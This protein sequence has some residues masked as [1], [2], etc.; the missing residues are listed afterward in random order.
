MINHQLVN[1]NGT[2]YFLKRN[3][4]ELLVKPDK[5]Q[6]LRELLKCDIVLRKDGRLWF[7]ELIPE[8]EIIE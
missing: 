5:I 3:F 1:Y 2:L 8:A 4:N 6:E 7:C